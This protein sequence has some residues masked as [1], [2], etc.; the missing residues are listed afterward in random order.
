M[1]RALLEYVETG[2]T[3]KPYT[4]ENDAELRRKKERERNKKKKD[5]Q[6]GRQ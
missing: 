1:L 3:V 6:R 2:R 5:K 4:G